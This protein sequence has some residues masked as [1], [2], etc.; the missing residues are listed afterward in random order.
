MARVSKNK[1]I[2]RIDQ[3]QRHTVGW[4]VQVTFQSKTH[5]KFFAD[6]LHGGKAK[7]LAAA[8]RWRNAKEKEIGKPRTNRVVM[9]KSSRNRSGVAGVYQMGDMYVVAWSP[10]PGELEREMVSI[11]K[12]GKKKALEKAVAIR[13]KKER[14]MYGRP[15]GE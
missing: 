11:S 7:A 5:R 4:F 12:H 14:E 9:P 10:K 2:A 15:L 1:G 6:K 8:I 3:P 13:K